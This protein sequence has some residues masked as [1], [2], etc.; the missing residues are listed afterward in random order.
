MNPELIT[1][2]IDKIYN[3]MF[4]YQ[5]LKKNPQI[6]QGW[7]RT[8]DILLLL[9]SSFKITTTQLREFISKNF[10]IE[11]DFESNSHKRNQLNR[12]IKK[13]GVKTSKGKTTS[14]NFEEYKNLITLP[15]FIDFITI[16]MN[17]KTLTDED[18]K[19]SYNELKNLLNNTYYQSDIYK[20]DQ[21][22]KRYSEAY[23]LNLFYYTSPLIKD[24]YEACFYLKNNIPLPDIYTSIPDDLIEVASQR[25]FA[26]YKFDSPE[27]IETTN[28]I[29]IIRMFLDD[30]DRWDNKKEPN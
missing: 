27:D 16:N 20:R 7:I 21:H 28:D 9:E 24:C 29:Q 14:L 5:T 17:F 19:N 11:F 10:G 2:D 18:K 25:E 12:F 15:E 23:I 6:K 4:F 30:I 26:N 8:K 1:F 22:S 13:I 3:Q